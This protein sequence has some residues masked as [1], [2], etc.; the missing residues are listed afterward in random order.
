MKKIHAEFWWEKLLQNSHM[1]TEK[2]EEWFQDGS[3][4]DMIK[5]IGGEWN[6]L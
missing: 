5:R 2:I 3:W 6:C 1:K 4:T